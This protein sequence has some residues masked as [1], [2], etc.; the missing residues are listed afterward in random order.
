MAGACVYGKVR[1]WV[2]GKR[3]SITYGTG[4]LKAVKYKSGCLEIYKVRG[5]VLGNKYSIGG[6]LGWVWFGWVWWVCVV[7]VCV[8]V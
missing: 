7:C 3:Q 5:R 6:C 2:L 4:C 1:E 8:C